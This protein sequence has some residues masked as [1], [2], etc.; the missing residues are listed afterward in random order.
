MG[1]GNHTRTPYRF[2]GYAGRMA[3]IR[4]AREADL[5][6]IVGLLA[7]DALGRMRE[8]TSSPVNA[9][10]QAAFSAIADD[11][12]QRLMVAVEADGEVVGCLQLTFIPGLS[13]LGMWRGQIES[14]RVAAARR[15]SASARSPWSGAAVAAGIALRECDPHRA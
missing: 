2:R 8:D 1:L 6:A 10:Y 3:T 13:R 11:E 7:D 15:G 14:V 12:N 4:R 5:P 9:A